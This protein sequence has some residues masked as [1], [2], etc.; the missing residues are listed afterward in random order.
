MLGVERTDPDQDPRTSVNND[1]LLINIGRMIM[2]F[3]L[4]ADRR[5]ISYGE[6]EDDDHEL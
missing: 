4:T 3:M 6:V 5:V 2:E 1:V